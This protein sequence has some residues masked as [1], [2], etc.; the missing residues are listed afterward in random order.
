M[1]AEI[2]HV[3]TKHPTSRSGLVREQQGED[4][5]VKK[6]FVDLTRLIRSIQRREGNPDCFLTGKEDCSQLDC[7]WREYCLK[8]PEQVV[9]EDDTTID[10][11]EA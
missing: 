10:G 8:S 5:D 9:S 3:H 4:L 2:T 1:Q 7:A 11:E 6:D